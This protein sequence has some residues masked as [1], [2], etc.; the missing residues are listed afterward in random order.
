MARNEI[1]ARHGR[2]FIDE[3]LQNYFDSC[4]WYEGYIEPEDFDEKSELSKCERKNAKLILKYEKK[5]G[6]R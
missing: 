3:E 5:K 2:L 4:S 6:Y 1:Y